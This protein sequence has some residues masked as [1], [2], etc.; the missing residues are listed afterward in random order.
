MAIRIR[1]YP[2]PGSIG[3]QRNRTM[4]RQRQLQ[5]QH[6]VLQR[7]LQRQHEI[8]LGGRG[9]G[10]LG[11]GT[12]GAGMI[13]SPFASGFGSFA[14]SAAWGMPG[15]SGWGFVGQSPVAPSYASGYA[16]TWGAIP[17]AWTGGYAAQPGSWFGTAPFAS[18]AS[19]A[20]RIGHWL[21]G[22]C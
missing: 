1:V 22:D 15:A 10:M 8:Q 17:G 19:V 9:F 14:G 21:T 11:G 16:P 4:R 5:R 18:P 6:L 13:G 20:Q 12:P 3:A 7:Q 2:Q